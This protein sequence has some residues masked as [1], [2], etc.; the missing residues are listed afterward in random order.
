[1]ILALLGLLALCGH[2]AHAGNFALETFAFKTV[3]KHPILADVYRAE[4]EGKRPVLLWIHGGALVMGSREW[5]PAWQRKLFQERGITVVSIDY[6]LYPGTK[7]PE[8]VQDVRDAYAWIRSKG[9]E[10]FAADPDR[11]IVA[12]HSAGAYLALLAGHRFRPTPRAIGVLSGFGSIATGFFSNA[13]ENLL[14]NFPPVSRQ[15]AEKLGWKKVISNDP[16]ISQNGRYLIY[17]HSRQKN[18][19]LKDLTGKEP[20]KHKAWFQSYTPLEHFGPKFPPVLQVHSRGDAVIPW[21]EARLVKQAADEKGGK[22]ELILL[23]GAAHSFTSEDRD[24]EDV[25]TAFTRLAD[26]LAAAVKR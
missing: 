10:L 6:R 12:G 1:M 4:G 16:E 5:L 7:L 11:L 2:G 3:G 24:R 18:T 25:R 17:V 20:G 14:K 9:P 19:W 15:E 26:F 13:S 22:H 23:D 21:D 8:I